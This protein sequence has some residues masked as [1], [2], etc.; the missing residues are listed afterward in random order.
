MRIPRPGFFVVGKGYV[1]RSARPPEL[2]GQE[3]FLFY[4]RDDENDVSA[5]TP[6]FNRGKCN[7]R[8]Y[9][10]LDELAGGLQKRVN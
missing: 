10:E 8:F 7:D 2:Q 5:I 9:A 1:D 4:S 3:G 6:F